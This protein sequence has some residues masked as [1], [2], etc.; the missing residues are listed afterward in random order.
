[1]KKIIAV[2]VLAVLLGACGFGLINNS[3]MNV[4]EVTGF[5]SDKTLDKSDFY[6]IVNYSVAGD[7]FSQNG[8]DPR[9][10]V[11]NFYM[12]VESLKI[13]LSEPLEENTL[14]E[15][16]YDKFCTTKYGHKGDTE[17]YVD[18][19][20][21]D[22]CSAIRVDINGDFSFDHIELSRSDFDIVQVGKSDI[23]IWAYVVAG[24]LSVS[25]AV[26]IIY[27]Y[28]ALEK[29]KDRLLKLKNYKGKIFSDKKNIYRLIVTVT[30]LA[31]MTGIVI[32][33]KDEYIKLLAA[34]IITIAFAVMIN[35][36]NIY[37]NMAGIA[38][39][40]VMVTGMCYIF[41][42]P[43]GALVSF[44]DEFHYK[45][46]VRFSHAFEDYVTEADEYIYGRLI[47]EKYNQDIVSDNLVQL[48]NLYELGAVSKD[49]GVTTDAYKTLSYIPAG[50]AMFI[51][52]GLGCSFLGVFY[53]GKFGNLFVYALLIYFAIR[54]IKSG[55]LIL[56]TVALFPTNIF[57]AASYT[58]DIW[59]TGFTLFGVAYIIGVLQDR[60]KGQNVSI[61]D[62]ALILGAFTL[63][64]APKAV[65]FPL[66]LLVFLI[67][68]ESFKNKKICRN[69]WIVTC[70]CILFV[71]MTFML[72]F[73]VEGPGEGDLRGG[74]DVNSIK[75]VSFILENPFEYTKILLN[76]I[77]MYISPGNQTETVGSLGYMGNTTHFVI[78]MM[79]LVLFSVADRN[80]TDIM[81]NNWKSKLWSSFALFAA[82]VL[83]STALYISFTPV[84]SK[85][86]NG[87]QY[88]Y[89]TPLVFPLMYFV[90]NI[91]TDNSRINKNIL[92]IVCVT[93]MVFILYNDAW[94][95]WISLY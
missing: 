91:K 31:G 38:F 55:K 1:M 52:R 12:K 18:T 43:V 19:E 22:F 15:L 83:V 3:R 29:I 67:P 93:A 61:K 27:G 81:V 63:G 85:L 34:A 58:Y 54:R 36:F 82:V 92:G 33:I 37:K 87:C 51:A 90:F 66:F 44:D 86:I 21:T 48:E 17:I 28:D 25:I 10:F 8:D 77:K 80:E 6:D 68:A 40:T 69:M 70:V 26:G 84:G 46:S 9:F 42:L 53:A 75:Q 13:V 7:R 73:V 95:L 94:K 14:I 2:I 79:L 88:R 76:H 20:K 71:L 62:M 64:F 23:S 65:Y 39:V 45:N 24:I 4:T 60:F 35:V 56:A 32:L 5:Q 50:T 49:G 89:L 78:I 59:L 41:T 57:L 72:P 47:T 30:Y 74:G 16:Y 11:T